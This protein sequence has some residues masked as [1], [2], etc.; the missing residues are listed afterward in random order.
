[1]VTAFADAPKVCALFRQRIIRINTS[2]I[3]Y[4]I[5]DNQETNILR[6]KQCPNCNELNRPDQKFCVKCRMV[7]TYDAYS[8]TVEE[9]QTKD[10]QIEEKMHKQEQLGYDKHPFRKV[11]AL[12]SA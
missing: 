5:K 12:P 4:T 3:W 2:R 1:M 11:I 8:E 9:K 6:P 10:K 7:L